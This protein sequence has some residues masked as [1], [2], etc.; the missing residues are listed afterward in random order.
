[1]SGRLT[2]IGLGFKPSHLTLEGLE[3]LKGASK[4]FY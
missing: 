3:A 2:M 4:I 1:M